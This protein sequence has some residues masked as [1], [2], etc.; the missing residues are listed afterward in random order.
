MERAPWTKRR[1]RHAFPRLLAVTSPKVSTGALRILLLAPEANPGS[2][3]NP[4]IGYYQAEA[5]ARLHEVTLVVYAANE[6]AVRR[7]GAPFHAIEPIR[8]PWIDPLHDWA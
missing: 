1:R 7:G 5:L 8:L 6:E 2:L 4:S 3:T